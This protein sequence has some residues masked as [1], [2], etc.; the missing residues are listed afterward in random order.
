MPSLL[1][2]PIIR[3]DH[4]K[5]NPL[6][7]VNELMGYF[8]YESKRLAIETS[9]CYVFDV[10]RA[11]GAH[12]RSSRGAGARTTCPPS[13]SAGLPTVAQTASRLAKWRRPARRE[14]RA[15][16]LANGRGPTPPPP[17]RPRWLDQTLP[18]LPPVRR[19]SLFVASVQASMDVN[20]LGDLSRARKAQTTQ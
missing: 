19:L 4:N 15:T 5:C 6:K 8:A 3:Q 16:R 1:S 9:K 20:E 10:A 13:S 18:D 17:S 14:N 7:A 11:S 12:Q 2:K